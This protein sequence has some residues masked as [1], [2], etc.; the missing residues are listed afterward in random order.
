MSQVR[1]TILTRELFVK[2][3]KKK[4]K[5]GVERKKEEEKEGRRQFWR[6]KT[7]E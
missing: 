5:R 7:E 3:K 2:M 4:K 1:S 6:F